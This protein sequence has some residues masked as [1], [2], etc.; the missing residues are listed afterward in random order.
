MQFHFFPFYS[1]FCCFNTRNRVE[2]FQSNNAINELEPLNGNS[3]TDA[4]LK[5]VTQEPKKS[6]SLNQNQTTFLC[7]AS[8]SKIGDDQIDFCPPFWF[9]DLGS[10]SNLKR[11]L[12]R[13]CFL[14]TCLPLCYPC[15]LTR[16]IRRRTKQ[17]PQFWGEF[18]DHSGVDL[19]QT[20]YR[21]VTMKEQGSKAETTTT[22]SPINVINVIVLH[23]PASYVLHQ[24]F[25]SDFQTG[26][27]STN[28]QKLLVRVHNFGRISFFRLYFRHS[29]HLHPLRL[30]KSQGKYPQVYQDP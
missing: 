27:S 10:G 12:W 25:K 1:W 8:T 28:D 14:V 26:N 22:T 24:Y 3:P 30:P 7:C 15:Y 23:S 13:L 17:R 29:C 6:S 21:Q 9:Q 2:T 20:L 11:F 18:T 16:T 4:D 19:N 5:V